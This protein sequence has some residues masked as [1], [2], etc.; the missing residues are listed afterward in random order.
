MFYKKNSSDMITRL[1]DMINRLLCGEKL[2][3][4]A[5][6]LE[7]DI[8]KRTIQRDFKLLCEKLPIA[9]E[10]NFYILKKQTLNAEDLRVVE[11]LES[12]SKTQG[13]EFEA[14]ARKILS[15]ILQP[16]INNFHAKLKMEDISSCAKVILEL[17][18]AIKNQNSISFTYKSYENCFKTQTNP[19]KIINDQGFW[20][21]LG[22]DEVQK[23]TK[24]YHLKS[25]SNIK[26]SNNKFEFSKDLSSLIDNAVNIWFSRIK[27]H[28]K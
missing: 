5:L 27:S 21:L 15:H 14:R 3:V 22:F 28:L 10:N 16:K 17:E 7:L 6:S 26:I 13:R 2:S 25:I 1:L 8:S 20:Y 12:L 4:N 9:K 18:T 24:K 19:L 23:H 11:I